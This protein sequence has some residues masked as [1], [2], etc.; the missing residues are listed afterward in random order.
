MGDF[1]LVVR[2]PG[3]LAAE[4][5]SRDLRRLA[6]SAGQTVSDL[7][8]CAWLAVGGPNPPKVLNVGAWALIGDVF[9]RRSPRPPTTDTNDLW[10]YERK[11]VAR[12]WGRFAGVLFGADKQILALLRDPSGATECVTWEQD[13][14]TIASSSAPLWLLGRL[15]PDWRIDVAGL[16]RA[17]RDPVSSAGPLLLQGPVSVGAGMLQPF[18]LDRQPCPLWRPADA[19][20]LSLRTGWTSDD[21]AGSLRSA[22]DE[23]VSAMA[24]LPG[25]LA[26]EI[27]GGLD[28]SI[29]ASSLVHARASVRLWLNAYGAVREADERPYVDA[30]GRSLG[31]APTAVPHATGPI[32]EAGLLQ[33]N[34][35]WRPGLNAMDTPHDLDWA[36]RFAAAGVSAVMTGKGGDS[37]LLQSVTPDVFADLWRDR[38]WKA[39]FSTDA[40]GLALANE[41]SVWTMVRRARNSRRQSLVMPARDDA[42]LT[43][44]TDE[45][46]SH[47]WLADCGVFGPAKTL[48]ILGVADS[49]SR[50]G[51]SMLTETIDVRHPLCAQPVIEACLAIPTPILTLGARDRGLARQAFRDRLP[52]EIVE[53]RSKGDMTQIYGRMLLENLNVLRPWLMEGRLAALGI[54]DRRAVDKQLTRERFM[55]RGRYS[56]IMVAAAFEGW[57][58]A[59]DARLARSV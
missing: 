59:W 39:L 28:S 46:P 1:V 15:R 32:T 3:D 42:L 36:S 4:A 27:S 14:L 30:L 8:P 48:Q 45:L 47:P 18:P 5:L 33:T 2:R 51:P 12:F 23:T 40:A 41:T 44:W 43:P 17:L 21:A 20:R 35:D 54:I 52:A 24:G 55:W 6:Q 31:L 56:A 57:V 29:V 38:G 37:I 7:N 19:A 25:A 11:L 9:N 26:A 34:Q 22:I 49:V 13:G 50:H 58:R 53:R 16:A 10:G